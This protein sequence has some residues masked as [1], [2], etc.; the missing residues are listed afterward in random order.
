MNPRDFQL[1]YM[2]LESYFAREIYSVA[3]DLRRRGNFYYIL[4]LVQSCIE[5]WSFE[6]GI[7][8][9][10]RYVQGLTWAAH[11]HMSRTHELERSNART[12]G[13]D[14]ECSITMGVFS[15]R[16]DG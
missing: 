1:N 2:F 15:V 14:S 7:N 5:F 8:T 16:D 6:A 4:T 13:S 11:S 9:S 12:M 10:A 3:C